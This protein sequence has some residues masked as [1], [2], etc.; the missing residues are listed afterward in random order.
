MNCREA[1]DLILESLTGTTPPDRRRALLAHLQECSS[2]RREAA[3]MEETVGML[4]AV[5]EPRLQGDLWAEFMVAL[6]RRIA[7]EMTGWRWLVRLL[8]TPRIAWGAAAA[9]SVVVVALAVIL[10]VWPFSQSERAAN[11]DAQA[12]LSGLVTESVVQSFPSMTTVLTSWKA[13]LSAPD[14]SYELTSTG[15]R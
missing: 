15:G 13:G 14:V 10:F 5:P 4:R 2:C 6:D 12:D 9:T 11:D 1:R 8:R 3:E 7:E